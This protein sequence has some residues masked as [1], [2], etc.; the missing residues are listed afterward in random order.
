M[1]LHE[2]CKKQND[3]RFDMFSV[4]LVRNNNDSSLDRI[5]MFDE[6]YIFYDS[7][8]RSAQSLNRD[9]GSQHF[10]KPPLYLKKAMVT[11]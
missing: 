10:P 8:R 3:L 9:Q 11:V 7:R 2:L 1:G 6:K 4:L 5:V